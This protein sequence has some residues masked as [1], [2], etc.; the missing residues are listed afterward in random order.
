M[1]KNVSKNIANRLFPFVAVAMCL[2]HLYTVVQPSLD[3]I[4]QQSVHLC[5]ALVLVF[6]DCMSVKGDK[7]PKKL[8]IAIYTALLLGSVYTLGYILIKQK[9]LVVKIGTYT[10]NDLF[11]GAL[12]IFILFVATARTFGKALPIMVGIFFLYGRFG[13][14][15]PGTLYHAGISWPRLVVG[16]TTNLAGVF[17]TVLEVSS[18]YIV[19]FMI[20][21]GLLDASGAGDFFIRLAMSLGGKSRSGPAQAAVISSGLVGSINGSAVANVAS[22]GVFTIPL[23]KDRGYEPHFAGAVEACASTGGMIMPPVMGVAAFVM[24]GITGIPY[25]TI[26]LSALVPALLYYVTI[27]FSVHLRALKR[28]FQPLPA[29]KIPALKGVLLDGGHFATPLICIVVLMTTGMSVMRAAFFG[30][31]SLLVVVSIRET[32]RNPRYLLQKDFYL[33]I[34]RGFVSGARS[35]MS[36]AAACAA[37]GI[38]TQVIINTGMAMKIVFL[39]KSMAGGKMFLALVMTCLISILFGMGVPTTASY[40]LVASLGA[41]VLIEMGYSVLSVHLFIYYYAI[42]ANITPPIASAALV[43][44]QIAKAP[45]MKTGWT[46][47]RLGLPGFLL[48]FLF[49]YH[50]EL[51]LQGPFL[52]C[53]SVILSCLLGMFCMAV[54]FERWF[55]T[56]L[57][58][59]EELMVA[60]ASFL[61]VKPGT[62]SDLAGLAL[63]LLLFA[64]QYRKRSQP[65]AV[66][67][68]SADAE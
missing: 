37:M 20:F 28:G 14:L 57:S 59:L 64:I 31:L 46:A 29:D 10:T 13:F 27:G 33:M 55:F 49:V 47:V 63:F 21:G 45:Y 32:I 8:S 53:A 25:G 16:V 2:F 5:F 23:M 36:V 44:S 22:T 4:Q 9:T 12:L 15:V 11:V 68:A 19:L 61:L 40:V 50:P 18:T 24:A 43:G 67:A 35:A 52:A 48:P 56:R 39:I 34:Y 3:T 30:C 51:L 26:A 1:E 38:M 65:A 60:A 58:V 6:L 62:Y 17:G 66:N 54:F 7:H 41:P 42:L